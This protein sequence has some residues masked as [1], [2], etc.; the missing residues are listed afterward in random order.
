MLLFMS[1]YWKLKKHAFE[2]IYLAC[3]H[4]GIHRKMKLKKRI[5]GRH[6]YYDMVNKTK[7]K[8]IKFK[9]KETKTKTKKTKQNNQNK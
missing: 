6:E 8:K 5:V 7:Q 2:Y 4:W 3:V 9:K 1:R